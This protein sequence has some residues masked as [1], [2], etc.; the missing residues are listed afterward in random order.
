MIS[1]EHKIIFIHCPKCAGES[2]SMALF[3]RVD[4]G[5]GKD[6]LDG[7][8]TKHWS[9]EDYAKHYGEKICEQYFTFSFVRNPWDQILSRTCFAKKREIFPKEFK[10]LI[11]QDPS[12]DTNSELIRLNIAKKSWRTF[13][14]MLFFKDQCAVDFVGKFENIQDD[15]NL[16][17]KKL[18]FKNCR[19]PLINQTPHRH[20]SEYYNDENKN[21]VAIKHAIDVDYFD[22]KFN[23]N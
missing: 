18:N 16:L 20:Y 21:L 22:Y 10:E 8:S 19:L 2:I 23:N 15:F 5:F 1:H 14:Q 11:K 6:G 17:C 7:T 4:T 3:G 9:Y 13:H 12:L